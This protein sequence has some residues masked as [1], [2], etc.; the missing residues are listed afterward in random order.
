MA[1]FWKLAKLLGRGLLSGSRAAPFS[2]L[3]TNRGIRREGGPSTAAVVAMT[4]PTLPPLFR[5]HD[6]ITFKCVPALAVSFSPVDAAHTIASQDINPTRNWLN[7][8]RINAMADTAKVIANQVDRDGFDEHLI[9]NTVGETGR[10]INANLGIPF[11]IP[12]GCPFPAWRSVVR[13]FSRYLDLGKDAGKKFLGDFWSLK[14]SRARAH[15]L[16][17]SSD[18]F[19]QSREI[20]RGLVPIIAQEFCNRSKYA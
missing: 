6:V 3:L 18:R 15:I 12:T 5:L 14:W 11:L 10:V 16:V 4:L 20:G 19:H 13:M 17:A 1:N 2:M 8:R 9:N 7:V